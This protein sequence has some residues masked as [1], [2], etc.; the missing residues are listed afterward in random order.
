M[1]FEKMPPENENIN[2]QEQIPDTDPIKNQEPAKEEI[3]AELVNDSQAA[4]EADANELASLRESMG[5]PQKN[6]AG[7][8]EVD[9]KKEALIKERGL[10]EAELT[11]GNLESAEARLMN[12]KEKIEARELDHKSRSLYKAAKQTANWD[13]ARRMIPLASDENGRIGRAEAWSKESGQSYE[14]EPVVEKNPNEKETAIETMDKTKTSYFKALLEAGQFDEA[15]AWVMTNKDGKYAGN[16]DWL[17][18]VSGPLFKQYRAKQD[19]VNAK[20]MVEMLPED[21]DKE[22]RRQKLAQEAGQPYEQI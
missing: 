7:F 22:N 17:K 15:E 3:L 18:H 11:A 4:Q 21:Q 8:S 16:T 1:D 6:E 14:G 5:L 20:R 12:L 19:W 13:L 2:P 9:P 10:F